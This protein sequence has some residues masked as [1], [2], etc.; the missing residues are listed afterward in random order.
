MTVFVPAVPGMLHLSAIRA[1]ALAGY[2][3]DVAWLQDDEAYG[4][5]L[6]ARWAQ[7]GDLIVVEHD[8]EI[9]LDTLDEFEQCPEPWCSAPYQV[10]DGLEMCIGCSRFR[11]ELRRAVPAPPGDHLWAN[12]ESA[13]VSVLRSAGYA[14][15]RHREVTHHHSY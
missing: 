6:A 9:N 3:L 11:E 8:V 12:V 7:P 2:E 14:P 15:H 1:I 5:E 13:Y 4:R 10:G